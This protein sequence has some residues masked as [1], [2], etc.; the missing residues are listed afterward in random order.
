[1]NIGFRVDSS[2]RI[3]LGHLSRCIFI[4]EKLKRKNKIFFISRNL[5]GNMFSQVKDKFSLVKLKRIKGYKFTKKAHDLL[6]NLGILEKKDYLETLSY[7]KK[8]KIDVLIIDHYSITQIYKK[9]IKK[10]IKYLIVIDDFINKKHFADLYINNNFLNTKEKKKIK[11]LN[12]KSRLALGSEYLLLNQK[13]NILKQRV[14]VRKKIKRILVF[15]GS[16]D[17][18]SE[19]EKAIEALKKI[20]D[21]EVIIIT[22][23]SNPRIKN[24]I[25]IVNE[26]EKFKIFTDI[27]NYKFGLLMLASDIAIG[28]CG[29]NLL[30]RLYLG[31][32][33]LVISTAKNQITSSLNLKK[34]KLIKYLG[35]RNNVSQN[36]IYGQ[37]VYFLNN[38]KKFKEFS[39]RC[40]GSIK[41]KNIFNLID[42]IKLNLENVK[43]RATLN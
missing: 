5:P 17:P 32:P 39:K 2:T 25:K 28:S 3:G 30:E 24:L 23:K 34:K 7:I 15:F 43:N 40:H 38:T 41:G 13:F 33:S 31:L 37:I 36:D 14:K 20:P 26:E 27:N 12:P 11:N 4:A 6:N 19:T 8:Y 10:S 9:L 35:D 29:V 21:I 42:L 22:T 1:M 16:I 18:S